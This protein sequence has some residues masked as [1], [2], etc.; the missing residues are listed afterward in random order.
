MTSITVGVTLLVL[1][2]GLLH[3]VWN[4]I[5][6]QIGDPLVG[7]TLLNVGVAVPSLVALPLIGL[8]NGASRGYLAAAVVCHLL[9]EIFLMQAYRHGSL[10]RS[11]PIARGVAPMLTTV[12]GLVF[13]DERVRGLALV[14]VVVV[15]AGTISLALFDRVATSR[16]AVVWALMTGVA[17][18]V[19]TVIDGLGVRASA[20]PLKYTMALFAVQGT[21]FVVGAVLRLPASAWPS[22][23][24]TAAGIGGGVLS[25]I[26]YGTVLYAQTRAP[27]GV[28]SAVRETGV[29]W[30]AVIGV[31]LF[32]EPG[33]WRIVVAASTVLVGIT[34]IAVT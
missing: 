19:Y 33:G 16:T 12:G 29:I 14:G 2:A 17:I 34:C 28:V 27:L 13:A 24:T 23:A 25:L 15:V 20:A 11:Y 31:V 3:A 32:R 4:A 18:A 26:G 9:Y 6:K 8:P 1:L 30:A 7:F 21:L 5:A 22:L 10:S